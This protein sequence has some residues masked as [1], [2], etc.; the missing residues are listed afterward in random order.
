MD[1][2]ARVLSASAPTNPTRHL[3]FPRIYF[4]SRALRDLTAKAGYDVAHGAIIYC[5][6]HLRY[7]QAPPIQPAQVKRLLYVGRLA[8]DKGVMTALRA[9]VC[10]AK[11]STAN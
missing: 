11:S 4:C 8:E 2:P 3:H 7:F 5:P 10:S 1:R 9:F 6:V